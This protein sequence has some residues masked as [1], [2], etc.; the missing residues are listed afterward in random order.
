L[1]Y[2]LAEILAII[3]DREGIAVKLIDTALIAMWHASVLEI[4]MVT[5][6]RN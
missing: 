4:I 3:K 1:L 6:Y 2:L 5:S